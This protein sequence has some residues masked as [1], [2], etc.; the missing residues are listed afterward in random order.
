M[1]QIVN[2]IVYFLMILS[3]DRVCSY[4]TPNDILSGPEFLSMLM[5]AE[6]RSSKNSNN[7][8]SGYIKRQSSP[9]TGHEY[10]GSRKFHHFY[11]DRSDA[12]D[13]I[14]PIEALFTSQEDITRSGSRSY[15]LRSR[16]RTRNG[17]L[18]PRTTSTTEAVGEVTDLVVAASEISIGSSSTTDGEITE[19][20]TI[21]AELPT[22]T[23]TLSSSTTVTSSINTSHI[24]QLEE[25]REE[26]ITSDFVDSTRSIQ[27]NDG[28]RPIN[29]NSFRSELTIEEIAP[30]IDRGI[31]T[32]EPDESSNVRSIASMAESEISR[33][34]PIRGRMQRKQNPLTPRQTVIYHDK[35][36]EKDQ[37]HS[38]SYSYIGESAPTIKTWKDIDEEYLKP[39]QQSENSTVKTVE[40]STSKPVFSEPAKIWSEPEKNY[41]EPAKVWSEPA[42]IYSEPAKFYSEPA[43]VYSEPAR[44]YSEPAKVYSQPSSYW[45]TAYE[46]PPAGPAGVSRPSTEKPADQ[47]KRIV[48][49]DLDKIPYDELNAPANAEERTSIHNAIGKFT[50]KQIHEPPKRLNYKPTP[51]P[52][53]IVDPYVEQQDGQTGN[54]PAGVVRTLAPAVGSPDDSKVG[55]VVEGRNYRK[56]RVEEKTPDGFIVGEYGVLSHNDGN[57]R[58][59]RYTA[60]SDANPRLIYDALLKF[61]SL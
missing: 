18:L 57:L 58:G 53:E 55:Y 54:A 49:N 28:G 39:A 24:P 43:K 33:V 5:D 30:S 22:E 10:R 25:K 44:I 41:S 27:L 34:Q 8:G 6:V 52:T 40:R 15:G 19:S 47:P 42:K 2:W 26:R 60:D 13:S 38:V 17:K 56:Y 35:E 61:L 31:K 37:P 7:G 4:P 1:E 3:I 46:N 14:L 59:V 12:E 20:T 16:Y 45:L 21:I 11:Y 32:Y 36:N 23:D 51:D 48:F 50:P 9:M 29:V